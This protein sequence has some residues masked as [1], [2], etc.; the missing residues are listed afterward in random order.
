[1]MSEHDSERALASY[2]DKWHG[3]DI[4]YTQD[5]KGTCL[6]YSCRVKHQ[7]DHAFDLEGRVDIVTWDSKRPAKAEKDDIRKLALARARAIVDLRSFA[8]GQTL[9]RSLELPRTSDNPQISDQQL[10]RKL[11]EV[12]HVI[13][14]AVPRSFDTAN[15]RV[16]TDGLCVELEISENQYISAITY[17]LEKRWLDEIVDRLGGNCPQ[18]FITGEGIDEYERQ[19]SPG[20][21]AQASSEHPDFSF[22]SNPDLRSI[23]E[24]DYAEVPRCLDATA[25]KAA[26]VMCG[27]V[28]EALLLDALLTDEAKAKQSQNAPRHKVGNVIKDLDRW[29]LSSMIEVGID[30]QMLRR[31]TLGL[32]SHA[33][34]EYRNLIHPGAEIREAIVAEK[35]EAMAAKAALDLIIKQLT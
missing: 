33:V 5:R 17:L 15:G 20:E 30:L 2:T 14:R 13:R 21:R 27:S 7:G 26:T 19:Q 12:F 8:W 28:M 24:R 23:I 6:G 25:Y 32:M 29:S 16:D 31:D 10:R 1:M 34:R 9:E 4:Y 22:V 35:E 11:L 3:F 18:V